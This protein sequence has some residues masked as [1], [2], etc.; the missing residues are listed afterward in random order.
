[1]AKTI[2]LVHGRHYKPAKDDLR[3]LW[4]EALSFGIERDHP[5]KLQAFKDAR[6]ELVY[7]GDISNA[8]LSKALNESV[9]RDLADRKKS[10]E[11]LKKLRRSQYTKANYRKLPGYNP[12]MEGLAD[13]FAGALNFFGFSQS[14]I[15]RVAPDMAEYWKSYRFG[16]DVREVFT[17]AII[18]AMKRQGDICVVGHSLGSMITYDVFWKLSHYGE[19]RN[20]SW[21][22][23][24]DL[25]ITIGSPL[26]DETVKDNLKGANRS[27]KD[28]YPT[29]VND[30]LNIAAEDDYI[31]HDQKVSNDFKA[32][33]RRGFVKSITDRRMYN[34]A[35]RGGKSNPHHGVGYLINPRMA[36]AVAGWL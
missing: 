13:T 29:N 1:M 33:K 28:R 16:S 15:E 36:D 35:V 30:W 11:A 3:K 19:Y 5:N 18:K 6:V 24:V 10:L 17:N 7:Y 34:M 23:K 8:Y 27:E 26:G 12:W 2:L 9:P 21:N 25:W 20:Q 31:S 14:I 22:R 32:M 4:T